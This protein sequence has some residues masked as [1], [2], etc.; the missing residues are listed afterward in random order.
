LDHFDI[1]AAVSTDT[2]VPLV[3]LGAAALYCALYSTVAMLLALVLFEDRD[4]A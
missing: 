3:Y 1:E 2:P 4:L